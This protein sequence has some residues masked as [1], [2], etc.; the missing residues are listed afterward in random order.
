MTSQSTL[1][2]AENLLYQLL[3]LLFIAAGIGQA[4]LH[5][6]VHS[7]M[8]QFIYSPMNSFLCVLILFFPPCSILQLRFLLLPWINASI[9]QI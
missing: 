1:Y 8:L 7:F 9:P 2:L 3:L 6:D 5:V 4:V